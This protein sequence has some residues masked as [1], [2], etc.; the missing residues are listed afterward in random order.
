[1]AGYEDVTFFSNSA[2]CA[3]L[4]LD[5]ETGRTVEQWVGLRRGPVG[6][7][8]E[9]LAR[10]SAPPAE[11]PP[12]V[13]RSTDTRKV[14]SLGGQAHRWARERRNGGCHHYFYYTDTSNVSTL[15][16]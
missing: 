6:L 3:P 4:H 8:L 9:R 13:R 15:R 5:T 11:A 1:M 14:P 10:A 2:A 12:D 16:S 7:V